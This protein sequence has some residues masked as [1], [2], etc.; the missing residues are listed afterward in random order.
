MKVNI[1]NIYLDQ[2][3]FVELRSQINVKILSRDVAP[4]GHVETKQRWRCL[5]EMPIKSPQSIVCCKHVLANTQHNVL[6]SV[7]ER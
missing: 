5:F 6:N 2:K 3:S 4:G 1:L 7:Y